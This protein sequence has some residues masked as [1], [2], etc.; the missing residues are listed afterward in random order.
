VFILHL[1]F[2]SLS[3]LDYRRDKVMPQ[4]SGAIHLP[5][6]ALMD[7]AGLLGHDFVPSIV[8][9]TQ[10]KEGEMQDEHETFILCNCGCLLRPDDRSYRS[11]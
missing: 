4:Q 10:R 3:C 9:T 8:Q 7:R 2:F 1:S 11:G 5:R 6:Y